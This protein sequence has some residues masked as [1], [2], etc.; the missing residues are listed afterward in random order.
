MCFPSEDI[1]NTLCDESKPRDVI[2]AMP[3]CGGGD[4]KERLLR[5]MQVRLAIEQHILQFVNRKTTVLEVVLWI[6]HGG[7]GGEIDPEIR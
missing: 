7:I 4:F 2:G 3:P 1:R 6:L 5:Y